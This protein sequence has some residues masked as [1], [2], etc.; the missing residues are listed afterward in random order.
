M[1]DKIIQY[2][3]I[4][5]ELEDLAY[6]IFNF[7]KENFIGLLAFGRH[8]AFDG[9]EIGDRKFSIKHFDRGYDIYDY[10]YLRI[11]LNRIYNNTWKE[12]LQEQNEKREKKLIERQNKEE[13]D[14]REKE[15][16]LLKELKEKYE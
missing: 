13:S 11:P 15:L 2:I 14:K 7:T 8:S 12:Y 9:W 1:K 3:E 16:L 4:E 6:T 10:S 5:K